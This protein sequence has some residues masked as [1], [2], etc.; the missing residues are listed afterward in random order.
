MKASALKISGIN[1]TTAISITSAS[2]AND[3]IK[4]INDAIE[5][6][7]TERSKLGA[8]QNRLTHTINN[9]KTTTENLTSAESRIRDVNMAEEIV[10]MSKYQI[11]TQA[12]T[13]MLSQ[14]NAN[15][16]NILRLLN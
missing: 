2:S 12:G 1:A 7:S 11:L 3:A 5:A 16:Q 14:A 8:T 4:T 9:L 13:A 10:K 15:P 6:V